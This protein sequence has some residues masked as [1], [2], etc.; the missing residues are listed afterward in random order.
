LG[1]VY[2]QEQLQRMD[3]ESPQLQSPSVEGSESPSS[4]SSPSNDVSSPSPIKEETVQSTDSP[5]TNELVPPDEKS[6]KDHNENG[7]KEG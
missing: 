6:K 2:Q 1:I 3:M 4:G 7:M 5:T